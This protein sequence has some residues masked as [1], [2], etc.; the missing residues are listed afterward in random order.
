MGAVAAMPVSVDVLLVA[1]DEVD[2]ATLDVAL[3][4]T[5]EL[6]TDVVAELVTVDVACVAA[7]VFAVPGTLCRQK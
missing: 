3:V 1:V 5:A 7:V 2:V 4:T 6:A